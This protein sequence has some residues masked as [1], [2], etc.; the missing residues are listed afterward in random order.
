[1]DQEADVVVC[2]GQL[3]PDIL[4][5]SNTGESFSWVNDNVN[6]GIAAAGAADITGVTAN[7]NVT[8]IP[9]VSTITVTPTGSCAGPDMVFTVTVSPDPQIDPVAD[10]IQCPGTVVGPLQN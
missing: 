5:S 8:G 10:I 7:V 2:S 3:I 9:E 1:M 6:T 4:F